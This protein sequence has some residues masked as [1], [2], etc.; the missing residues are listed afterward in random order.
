MSSK[1]KTSNL[2]KR[3][4]WL[5]EIVYRHGR[6]TFEEINKLWQKSIL[7][8]HDEDFPLR[9]FHNHRTAIEEMFDIIIDCDKCE[10][11][12]YYIDNTDDLKKEGVRNW[13]LNS[14]AVNNLMNESQKL[15]HRIL[16][17]Q[18][19]SGQ[20]FLTSIIEAMRDD[21]TLKIGYKSF[22]S[23]EPSSFEIE[24]YCIKVFKQRWYV[25]AKSP[26]DDMLRIYSLDR[27]ENLQ[28]TDKPFKMPSDFC[29][30]TYF[31]NAFGIT[32]V[33]TIKPCIVEIMVFGIQR[34]YLQSLPLHHS[35][36]EKEITENYT[37][38]SYHLAP[39]FDF[40]QEILSHGDKIK[41]LQ[42][43]WFKEE[44]RETV[45]DMYQRYRI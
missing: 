42:P 8:E 4:V 25:L 32:V 43:R 3:Y 5:L 19:P 40:K 2:F 22:R 29:A 6:I 39:T 7:N 30:E 24:P 38:F 28:I 34:K 36:K 23:D 26:F 31:E 13:L 44:V 12:T 1:D 27:I 9:T 45:G 20:R 15:K 14:F 33:E 16:F 11:Y 21:L 17:E 37:V 35:Q 18:I 10:G 41:V